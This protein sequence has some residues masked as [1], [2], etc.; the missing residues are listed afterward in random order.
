MRSLQPGVGSRG[1]AGRGCAGFSAAAVR[2]EPCGPRRGHWSQTQC[3]VPA[4]DLPF[5]KS[6]NIPGSRPERT[7]T[8]LTATQPRPA[9][10]SGGSHPPREPPPGCR[11]CPWAGPRECPGPRAGPGAPQTP[12]A[13]PASR[14]RGGPRRTGCRRGGRPP[15]GSCC[16]LLPDRKTGRRLGGVK[17]TP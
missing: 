15:R 3:P 14:P 5:V 7:A 12:G 9:H 1:H 2:P 10:G 11:S 8:S 4:S 13:D 16:P 17:V 6:A